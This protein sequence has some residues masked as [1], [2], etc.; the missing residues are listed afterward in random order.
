MAKSRWNSVFFIPKG[1]TE[2]LY[3][4]AFEYGSQKKSVENNKYNISSIRL[5]KVYLRYMNSF[6]I[7]IECNLIYVNTR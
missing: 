1:E 7:A 5:I 6:T 2:T 3:A 4:F